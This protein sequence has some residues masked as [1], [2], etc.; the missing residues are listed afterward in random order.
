MRGKTGAQ[1]PLGKHA[2]PKLCNGL[3][4][5][6][7]YFMNESQKVPVWTYERHMKIWWRNLLQGW[8]WTLIRLFNQFAVPSSKICA[9]EP[10]ATGQKGD[11]L[12]DTFVYSWCGNHCGKRPYMANSTCQKRLSPKP[13]YFP[14]SFC[15]PH[16]EEQDDLWAKTFQIDAHSLSSWW[17][18]TRFV[19]NAPVAGQ[20]LYFSPLF[21]VE[22]SVL[23]SWSDS[24]LGVD[25]CVDSGRSPLSLI[26]MMDP[27]LMQHWPHRLVIILSLSCARPWHDHQIWRTLSVASRN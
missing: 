25:R 5:P 3:M 10:I 7:F 23:S 6:G 9:C 15:R 16:E 17:I 26:R 18:F 20:T 19:W 12:L 2:E 21:K 14:D 27:K 13:F 11:Q 22:S 8:Q 4:E 1:P 24:I